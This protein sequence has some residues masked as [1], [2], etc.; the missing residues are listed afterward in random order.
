MEQSS[1]EAVPSALTFPSLF[2]GV[3]LCSVVLCCVVLCCA[4]WLRVVCLRAA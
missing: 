2:V 3:V 4:R 1:F